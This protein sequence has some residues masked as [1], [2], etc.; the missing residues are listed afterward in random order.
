MLYGPLFPTLLNDFSKDS[1][2]MKFWVVTT[3]SI[4]GLQGMSIKYH[5][6]NYYG[7]QT[8]LMD[9]FNLLYMYGAHPFRG[10]YVSRGTSRC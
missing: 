8:L 7:T 9:N 6:L 4:A 10:F 5:T 2:T 3:S 1:T